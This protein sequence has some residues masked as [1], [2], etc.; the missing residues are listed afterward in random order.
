MQGKKKLLGQI[1]GGYRVQF[2]FTLIELMIVVAIIGILAAIAYPAYTSQV[3]KGQRTDAKTAL[4]TAAQNLERCFTENNAYI[5]GG[6][7]A[8]LPTTSTEGYYSIAVVFS[9]GGAGFTLTATPVSGAVVNDTECKT[10][11]L[12][13]TGKQTSTPPG[14][15]CW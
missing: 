13:N 11:S 7:C 3:M 8:T 15:Q 5:N 2:G 10:F 6:V 12:D 4:M 14:N 9:A 1:T